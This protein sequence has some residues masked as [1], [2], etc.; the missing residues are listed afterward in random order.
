MSSESSFTVAVL[1]AG[2]FGTALAYV[3]GQ[4]HKVKLLCRENEQKIEINKNH[5]NPKRFSEVKLPE[6]V[7]ATTSIKDCVQGVDIILHCIPAQKTQDFVEK[8]YKL[9]PT[10]VPYV[11]TSKGIDTK[12]GR[13]MSECLAHAFNGRATDTVDTR[14]DIPLAFLSGP[15]FAADMVSHHPLSVVVASHDSWCAKRVQSILSNK[16]FR[17]Y[18][19]DNVIGVEVGGAL[20]NPLAIGTGCTKGL[21][22]GQSTIA[23]IVTRGCLEMSQLALAL[24]GRA[25]TLS[26]LSGFGDL[27]LTCYS[28]KSRNNRFGQALAKGLTVEE[29]VKEI[30]EV[31]E[32][33][34]TAIE[35]EKLATRLN[36]KL[37]LFSAVAKLVKG[38]KTP[39][40]IFNS[41]TAVMP[42]EERFIG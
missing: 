14:A 2:S 7:T 40:E 23:G 19:T 41:L 15:S 21:G 1:G 18:T 20:K 34:P 11:S 5:R 39:E 17:V 27:M 13:L 9:F 6:N 8:N 3:C 24:G 16:F 25:E 36:L 22:F 31:V 26:G 37:P 33:F 28:D 29:A 30:G 32:G 38:E 42:S 12:N 35:V 10:N 4:Q